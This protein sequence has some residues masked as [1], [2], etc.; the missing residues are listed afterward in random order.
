MILHKNLSDLKE[1][2]KHLQWLIIKQKTK[3]NSTFSTEETSAGGRKASHSNKSTC[4]ISFNLAFLGGWRLG[5]QLEFEIRAS[6]LQSR[7]S[8]A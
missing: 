5:V 2:F 1:I 8:T 6:H 7:C 4:Q 3:K